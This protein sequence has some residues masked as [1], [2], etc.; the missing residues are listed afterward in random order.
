VNVQR[1]SATSISWFRPT[2]LGVA[3]VV[4]ATLT[5]ATSGCTFSNRKSAAVRKDP[6]AGTSIPNEN[7]PGAE[8]RQPTAPQEHKP[9]R[10][11]PTAAKSSSSNSV[12]LASLQVDAEADEDDGP[13]NLIPIPLDNDPP[14]EEIPL[15]PL[16]PAQPLDGKAPKGNSTYVIDLSTALGLAGANNLQVQLARERAVQAQIKWHQAKAAMLPSLWF[17]VGW[18]R[19]DGRLQATDGDI[20]ERDRNSLFGGGGAGLEGASVAGGSGGPSRLV[21]NFSL[22]D[23]HFEPLVAMQH[24]DAAAAAEAK[25][26][27]NSMLEI[28]TAY[29]DLI[30]ARAETANAR[31][32]REAAE[33][34]V[35]QTTEFFKARSIAESEVFRAKA[36]YAVWRRRVDEG[37]RKLIRA[38]AE[39][40]RLLRLSQGAQLMPAEE[41][42]A[43]LEIVDE[44][45]SVQ[46]LIA[47]ALGGRP[48][49]AEHQALVQARVQQMRQEHWRPWLPYVQIGASGG[50]FGGGPRSTFGDTGGRTDVDI[51]AVWELTNLGF[52][53]ALA[54]RER[55]SQLAQEEIMVEQLQDNIVAEVISAA[56]DVASYKR[57]TT[58]AR[59]GLEAAT[60][61]YEANLNRIAEGIGLPIEL[62]QAIRARTDAQNAYSQSV[63]DYN[64]AQY[65]LFHAMG[66]MWKQPISTREQIDN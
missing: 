21:V 34:M 53:N 45:L 19:H 39:L 30:E 32:G 17:G 65:R 2:S 14:A 33:Q 61:S 40:A 66:Q 11:P 20:V 22:A 41:Q 37:Q 56:A 43:P 49:L 15:I 6:F 63:S 35:D 42:V 47:Q 13:D 31:S 55:R 60:R 4:A 38:G 59:E 48:E 7:Q 54:H 36:E 50:A 10:L 23:A 16:T 51:L 8:S 46:D 58:A 26:L 9:R 1:D 24:V 29:F 25:D 62:I 64:R 52:G 18:N 3:L 28:A 5:I 27:N 12:A 44:S 57:Q